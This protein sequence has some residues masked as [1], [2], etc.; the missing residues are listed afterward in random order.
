VEV[1]LTSRLSL[2]WH[3][4]PAPPFAQ[5]VVTDRTLSSQAWG[6]SSGEQA[7]KHGK[8]QAARDARERVGRVSHTPSS[9]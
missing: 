4:I 3:H 1:K 7:S 9:N 6:R 5:P 2:L 8:L